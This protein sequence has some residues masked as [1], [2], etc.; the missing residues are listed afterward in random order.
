LPVT[1]FGSVK[2]HASVLSAADSISI[3]ATALLVGVGIWVSVNPPSKGKRWI[4]VGVFLTLGIASV[5]ASLW[6]I[7]DG[8]ID[9]ARAKA[10]RTQ[11][12]DQ[13]RSEVDRLRSETRA[14][15]E[16]KFTPREL[17]ELRAGFDGIDAAG[18]IAVGSLPKTESS[19]RA[20]ETIRVFSGSGCG[21]GDERRWRQSLNGRGCLY[22][23]TQQPNWPHRRKTAV[24]VSGGQEC[25]G[26]E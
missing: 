13:L 18:T 2:Q 23:A 4:L 10:G 1:W 17:D 6:Q 14:Q 3:V 15:L 7:A 5:S 16:W 25:F 26:G 21:N 12:N 24:E 9:A 22:G 20:Q 19:L 8:K 11:E